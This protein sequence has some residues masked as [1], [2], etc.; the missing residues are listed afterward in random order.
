MHRTFSGIRDL[1]AAK[2]G[3]FKPAFVAYRIDDG[4]LDKELAY[5]EW[6]FFVLGARYAD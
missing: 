1:Y 5:R 2:D 3:V 4:I 6:R